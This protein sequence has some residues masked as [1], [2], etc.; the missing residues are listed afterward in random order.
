M[1]KDDILGFCTSLPSIGYPV[2][3]LFCDGTKLNELQTTAVKSVAIDESGDYTIY[4]FTTQN[5]DYQ[6]E[7]YDIFWMV[8]RRMAAC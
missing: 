1:P 3:I 6:L 5:S 8:A 2:K 7:V 4:K